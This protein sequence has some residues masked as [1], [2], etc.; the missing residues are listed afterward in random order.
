MQ[1]YN[2][3]NNADN[4]QDAKQM[5]TVTQIFKYNVEEP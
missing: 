3:S 1:T 2:N 4:K 5:C